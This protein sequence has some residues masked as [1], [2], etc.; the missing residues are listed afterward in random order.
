MIG[1]IPFRNPHS[2]RAAPDL[3]WA[4]QRLNA[5]LYGARHPDDMTRGDVAEAPSWGEVTR[6]PA[7]RLIP[8]EEEGGR[9]VGPMPI[10]QIPI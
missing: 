3:G 5:A 2:Q 9:A 6:C 1:T 8:G 7:L 10:R 4:Q